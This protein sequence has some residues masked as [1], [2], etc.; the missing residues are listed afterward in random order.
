MSFGYFC[1]LQFISGVVKKSLKNKFFFSVFVYF[2]IL[3]FLSLG[4]WQII[5]LNW[6]LNLISEIEKNIN[7]KPVSFSGKNLDNFKRVEFDANLNNS[8]LIFLYSLNEEGKP[9]FDIINTISIEN[10]N[11][12]LNRGWIPNDLKNS[13]FELFNTNFSGILKKKSNKNYFKPKNDIQNNYWFTLNDDDLLKYTGKKFSNFII[14]ETN[15]RSNFP[16]PKKI[17]V[18]IS[19]NHLKYSLTWFSLAISIFL[20]YLYFRKKNY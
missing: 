2:F 13:N 10:N 11:F 9:G 19:N 4:T 17:G 8:K 16:N 1:L 20:I 7:S 18:N 3:I 6:K 14:Y 5:R 15:N 12:L